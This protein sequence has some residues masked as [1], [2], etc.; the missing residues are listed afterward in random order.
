MN[1]QSHSFVNR[2]L[3]STLTFNQDQVHQDIAGS[4]K[5]AL[6]ELEAAS[7]AL[8]RIVAKPP[9]NASINAKTHLKRI[10]YV[11]RLRETVFSPEL[12]AD[13]AWDMLLDLCL[14]RLEDRKTSVSSLLIA[15]AVP[16][17]TALR[18]LKLLENEGI[19]DRSPDMSDARRSYVDLTDNSF[20]KLIKFLLTS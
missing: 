19:I 13:P 16:S 18:W 14:A 15:A 11:R 3:D 7:D 10:I 2:E 9:R 6:K 17:S 1:I 4:I 8:Q 20:D 5:R 12:F